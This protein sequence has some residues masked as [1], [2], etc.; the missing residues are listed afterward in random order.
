MYTETKTMLGR[1]GLVSTHV[2][3]CLSTTV[4]SYHT[5]CVPEMSFALYLSC[6]PNISPAPYLSKTGGQ[7]ASSDRAAKHFQLSL[8]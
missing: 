5:V 8:F 1:C 6:T 3:A 4:S 7:D 2:E